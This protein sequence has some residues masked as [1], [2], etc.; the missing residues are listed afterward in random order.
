LSEPFEGRGRRLAQ[1]LGG[2]V[3]RR[4]DHRAQGRR[5]SAGKE[6]VGARALFLQGGVEPLRGCMIRALWTGPVAAGVID[7][8]LCATG[9][10]L[11]EARAVMAALALWDGADDLA[12]RGGEGRRALQIRWRKGVEDVAEGGRGRSPCLSELMR[13]EASSCPVWVRGQ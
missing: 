7:A 12:V 8:V 13:T 10:A 6:K 3:W 5:G 1:G 4:A 9:W 11:R 2:D